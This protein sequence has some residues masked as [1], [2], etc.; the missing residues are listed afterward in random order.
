MTA[1]FMAGCSDNDSSEY[2]ELAAKITL[3][4]SEY[5]NNEGETTLHP[6]T[7]DDK[8]GIFV[9]RDNFL[10][11]INISP[12]Q[13]QS[14]KSLFLLN[15]K[16]P[17][18]SNATLVAFYPAD[19]NLIYED[20]ILKT[21]IP[22][23]Q[24]GT[25]APLLIGQ[26]TGRIDSYEGLHMELKHL[27]NTMYIPV[28]GSHAIAKAVIQANGGEAI[29]GETSIRL[30]D[31]VICASEKSVTVKFSTP[32]DCSAEIK[33]IPVMLAPVT[34]SQGYSVTIY[35]I[36]GISY[37]VSS[38][39]P[40][41][42]TAGGKADADEARSPYVI[43]EAP[44]KTE[45]Y[46]SEECMAIFFQ[47][48]IVEMLDKGTFWLSETPNIPSKG[49]DANYN[50][51]CTWALFRQKTTGK[52]FYFFNTHLDNSGTVARKES[53]KLIINK[54]EEVNSEQLPVFLTADFNSDTD[55]SCFNPLHQVMKDARAT[56]PV[57]DQEATYNG[58]KTSGTRKLDH[59]FYDNGCV[60]SIFQ[61]LKENYGAPY[62]SDH[63]PVRTCFVLF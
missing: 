16:A 53:I 56:A 3:T 47:T 6:W 17:K 15:F 2:I 28:W 1:Y 32:L 8:A 24:T 39:K 30:K 48:S 41:T 26:T 13:T 46:A 18:H 42:L 62:I 5:Y 49:W 59:I 12:I 37:T 29:A 43:G 14:P 7:K 63:Y 31:G 10:Q 61:T 45:T 58:Y 23:T 4:Q 11:K 40:I 55:E 27:F 9:I 60:A 35:D 44:P 51:S 21:T 36:N 25:V 34:L 19:A 33:L 50:R 20:D 57:T 38:D 22:T 52:R 54:I